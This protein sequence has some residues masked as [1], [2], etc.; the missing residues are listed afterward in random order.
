VRLVKTVAAAGV[1]AVSLSLVVLEP[2]LSR[3]A[4]CLDPTL[5]KEDCLMQTPP[6]VRARRTW[7]RSLADPLGSA[8]RSVQALARLLVCR[9]S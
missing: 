9:S 1:V 7:R 3:Q 2:Q 4:S 6:H 5:T 8:W